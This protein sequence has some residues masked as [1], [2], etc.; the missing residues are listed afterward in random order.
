MV[1]KGIFAGMQCKGSQSTQILDTLIDTRTLLDRERREYFSKSRSL[2][3]VLTV[4][5]G[6]PGTRA[7]ALYYGT[8]G[9]ATDAVRDFGSFPWSRMSHPCRRND[10]FTVMW[11]HL[12]QRFRPHRRH[13]AVE[14]IPAQWNVTVTFWPNWAPTLYTRTE[15]ASRRGQVHRC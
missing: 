1:P 6:N 12:T 3:T 4:A 8:C 9:K 5:L 2:S 11:R 14:L 10:C 7:T 13:E 15:R